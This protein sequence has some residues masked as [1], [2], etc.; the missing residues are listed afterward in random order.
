[1]FD[2]IIQRLFLILFGAVIIACLAGMAIEVWAIALVDAGRVWRGNPAN[3]AMCEALAE[4]RPRVC[5]E[6]CDGVD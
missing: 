5:K 6:W 4:R 2:K 1:M 3:M